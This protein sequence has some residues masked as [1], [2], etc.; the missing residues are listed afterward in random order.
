MHVLNYIS[1]YIYAC[2]DSCNIGTGD[3]PYNYVAMHELKTAGPRARRVQVIP[4]K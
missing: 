4:F 3:L 2:N 1:M